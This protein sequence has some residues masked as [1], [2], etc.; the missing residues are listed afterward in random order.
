MCS[1]KNIQNIDIKIQYI[2]KFFKTMRKIFATSNIALVQQKPLLNILFN[3][4][5]LKKLFFP[6]VTV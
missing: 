5:I 3:F 1:T 6:P 2:F 4:M